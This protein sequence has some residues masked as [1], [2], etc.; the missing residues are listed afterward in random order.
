MK[1]K[2][3]FN[4]D[5]KSLKD[6]KT[7]YKIMI[8]DL[9]E[10]GCVTEDSEILLSKIIIETDKHLEIVKKMPVSLSISNI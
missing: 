2:E 7:K 3:L 6:P 5:E 10:Y 8:T 9:D 4:L 1:I